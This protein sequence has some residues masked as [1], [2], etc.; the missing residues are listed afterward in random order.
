MSELPFHPLAD[1][2]PLIEGEPFD[3]M[4]EDIRVNGQRDDIVTLDEMILDGRNRFRACRAAEVEPRCRL[5]GSWSSDGND[6]EAFVFSAN[7]K[8]RH[9]NASQCAMIAA[10]FGRMRQGARTDL[11]PPGEKSQSE[12]ARMVGVGKR[13]VERA[14][15]IVERGIPAL[16]TVVR[17]GHL[18]V[19]VAA[20]LA[21]LP[22]TL[23]RGALGEGGAKDLQK[24]ARMVLVKHRRD[25]RLEQIAGKTV[26]FPGRRYAVIYC[27][28]PW[29]FV[30]WSTETG[31]ERSPDNHYPTMT[32]DELA[33]LP[34]AD[35]AAPDCVL[36]FW[37]TTASLGDDIELMAEWGFV[38]LRPR[39]RNGRLS[40]DVDGGLLAPASLGSYRSHQIW[41]KDRVGTGYWY[42]NTHELLLVGVRGDVPAPL[43]G[44]QET[45]LIN[46]PVGAHS[47]KPLCF[48]EMID[49]Q[50]PDLPKIELFCRGAPGLG[51]DAYG[52]EAVLP[53]PIV[54][55]TGAIESYSEERIAG[56]DATE[57]AEGFGD[58]SAG[59]NAGA[60]R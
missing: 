29:R 23:Q 46:A 12:R 37:S 28:I 57:I 27:D 35:L 18:S 24:R 55:P 40:R 58:G 59:L 32:F 5:F 50:Y 43:A 41:A 17:A 49:R 33:A 51:W 14:D 1:L 21:E 10:D 15:A 19:S 42:R 47:Q 22:D 60:L 44:A 54:E 34:V 16:A 52:N 25:A 8:R 20:K 31:L 2:F 36:F 38:S 26:A 9:L 45:S 4:V 53:P 39:E 30:A 7:L 13:S 3:E 6:P 11:S 48:R 56:D